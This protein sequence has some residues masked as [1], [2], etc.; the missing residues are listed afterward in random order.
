M[1]TQTMYDPEVRKGYRPS[2]EKN[3][4]KTEDLQ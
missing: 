4:K 2:S 1:K 3:E